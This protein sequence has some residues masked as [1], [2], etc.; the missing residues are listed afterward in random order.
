M[1]ATGEAV[2][3]AG[4]FVRPAQELRSDLPHRLGC[5]L[6]ADGRVE[7]DPMGRT[8]VPRVFVAG[9]AGPGMQ[10]VAAAMMSGSVAGAML[11]HDLLTADFAA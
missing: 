5:P 4:L 10:S 7:A 2:P 11:N 9:D 6:T 8:P 1:L 3:R